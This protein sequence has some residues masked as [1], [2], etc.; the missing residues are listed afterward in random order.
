MLHTVPEKEVHPVDAHI[1]RAIRKHRLQQGMTQG[2]VADKVGVSFQQIQKY[3]KG[4]GH[5]SAFR[6]HQIACVLGLS[7]SA[8]FPSEEVAQEADAQRLG[9]HGA[10]IMRLVPWLSPADKR[11]VLTLLSRLVR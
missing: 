8:F 11:M 9:R 1:G 10:E 6:L 7:T 4:I 3:E 2:D 5:L